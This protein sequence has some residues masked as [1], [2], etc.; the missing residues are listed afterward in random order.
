VATFR[1]PDA[2]RA[3]LESLLNQSV[4]PSL[5][6]VADNDPAQSARAVVEAAAARPTTTLR[7]LATGHNLGPAG[8]WAR[9]ALLAEHDSKRGDW[10]LLVDDDD[11]I[12]EPS[13]CAQMLAK[14]VGAPDE[15]AAIGL[16]GAR[17]RP[18][19]ASLKRVHPVDRMPQDCDYLASNGVPLYR[20]A[21][22]DQIGFFDETLFFGFEDLEFGLRLRAVGL[23]LQVVETETSFEVASTS[24]TRTAW[25]EYFKTRALVI[26]AQRHLDMWALTVITCRSVVLG[27]VLL[28][29][30]HRDVSLMRARCHGLIDGLRGRPGRARYIPSDNP[31]KPR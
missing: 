14:A 30:K 15:V 27:G 11:P 2:L 28:T 9:A 17:W 25:R 13:M 21:V 7:Y 8:A 6:V 19:R 23:R 26:T 24:P 1:R 31:P 18:T 29:V 12:A 22:L 20:W 5:V 16:R 10:L 4:P 3:T